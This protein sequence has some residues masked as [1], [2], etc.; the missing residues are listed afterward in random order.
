MSVKSLLYKIYIKIKERRFGRKLRYLFINNHSDSL[1]I[2]FSGFSPGNQRRY[3]YVKSFSG[4]DVDKLYILDPYAYRGS[5]YL[6]ESGSNYPQYETQGLIDRILKRKNY[7]STY[8]SGSSKGGSAALFYGINNRATA[9]FSGAC[10]YNIGTYLNCQKH[11]DIFNSMMGEGDSLE[12][13]KI[14]NNSI[15]EIVEKNKGCGT[16]IYLLFSKLEP[17]YQ[18][19]IVDLLSD[20]NEY[21]YKVIAIEEKF[22]D[23]GDVG[24]Y[25]PSF[26]KKSIE[27]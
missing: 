27:I 20:L 4:L 14:L 21:N 9:V 23:H 7:K 24:S 26:V 15:R 8:F 19:E 22:T 3:N 16:I 10:Q 25:F 1:L 6:Y 5:Y 11:L 18:E 2:V 12:F 17:T 13:T